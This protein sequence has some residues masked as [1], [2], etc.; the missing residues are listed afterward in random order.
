MS[1]SRPRGVRRSETAAS[2]ISLGQEMP[3]P[4]STCSRQ[5]RR[6]FVSDGSTDC[7]ECVRRGAKCCDVGLSRVQVE[8]LKKTRDDLQRQL[9][10]AED[11]KLDARR[12]E[13]E[14]I[15]WERRVRK[16]LALVDLR[17]KDM[18][19]KE[20]AILK[21]L[22]ARDEAE[23]E[24]SAAP[25]VEAS[26][27]RVE[28]PVSNVVGGSVSVSEVPLNSVGASNASVGGSS[29]S[30]DGSP[31]LSPSEHFPESRLASEE[32]TSFDAFIARNSWMS[33]D[34]LPIG[35]AG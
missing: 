3:I 28:V 16:Q 6:C 23:V 34:D 7:A 2:I 27:S 30:N 9:E 1:K 17:A 10:K 35:L 24:K 33:C 26:S 14:A 32:L 25:V 13:T 21:S 11:A 31:I 5:S 22:D 4:C 12:S 15:L 8:R 20:E 19:E 18:F 29:F